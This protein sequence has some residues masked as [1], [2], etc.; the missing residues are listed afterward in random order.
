LIT[1]VLS[2]RSQHRICGGRRACR[3][4]F[5]HTAAIAEVAEFSGVTDVLVVAQGN[6]A[7]QRLLCKGEKESKK[8]TT[9]KEDIREWEGVY[10]KNW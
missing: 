8:A 7:A 1:S 10:D 4:R 3:G 2:V 5:K 9:M 6:F